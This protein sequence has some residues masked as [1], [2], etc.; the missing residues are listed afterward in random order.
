MCVRTGVCISH[1]EQRARAWCA[2]V[3]RCVL[4]SNCFRQR[5]RC[6]VRLSVCVCRCIQELLRTYIY[7]YINYTYICSSTTVSQKIVLKESGEVTIRPS[8]P[9]QD[10]KEQFAW[11]RVCSRAGVGVSRVSLPSTFTYSCA[12]FQ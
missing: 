8:L 2:F 4:V 5:W 10:A 11:P 1:V 3:E 9:K 6:D 7:V 12:L